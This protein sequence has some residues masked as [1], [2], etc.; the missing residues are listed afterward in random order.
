MIRKILFIIIS[1]VL[2][3]PIIFARNVDV[4][5]T[6]VE[7]LE[8]SNKVTAYD[9][10][11]HEDT[12]NLDLKFKFVDD[13][14][15]YKI[16]IISKESEDFNLAVSSNNKYLNVEVNPTLVKANTVN[17]IYITVKYNEQIPS[18]LIDND[19][20][21]QVG[22][23]FLDDDNNVVNPNTMNDFIPIFLPFFVSI[24]FFAFLII[25]K[26]KK[27]ITRY[28]LF[29]LL[30]LS[31]IPICVGALRKYHMI[32]HIDYIVQHLV[33]E[34]DKG[35]AVNGKINE[36]SENHSILRFSRSYVLPDYVEK[37]VK[38]EMLELNDYE[39]DED[40]IEVSKSFFEHNNTY[41]IIDCY[42][43]SSGEKIYVIESDMFVPIEKDV[44]SAPLIGNV[45]II[46]GFNENMSESAFVNKMKVAY[47]NDGFGAAIFKYKNTDKVEYYLYNPKTESVYLVNENDFYEN[48][49]TNLSY[50]EKLQLFSSYIDILSSINSDL[51]I[52]GWFDDGTL[53]YY[54]DYKYPLLNSDSS[55]MFYNLS[56][57]KYVDGIETIESTNT[58]T[59]NSMF[60]GCNSLLELNL[61]N[62]DM[63]NVKDVYS[64]VYGLNEL[65]KL[66]TPKKYFTKDDM[67]ISLLRTFELENNADE[68]YTF[69]DVYSPL[70]TTLIIQDMAKF[71]DGYSFAMRIK[72]LAGTYTTAYTGSNSS[73]ERIAR[74]NVLPSNFIASFKNTLSATNSSFPIY[75]WYSSS[76]KTLYYYTK[77][78]KIYLNE[79]SNYMFYGLAGLKIIDDFDNVDTS[80]VVNMREMFRSDYN[81]SDFSFLKKWDTSNV[82]NMYGLFAG[83]SKLVDL[84]N[85]S[86]WDTSNVTDMGSLFQYDYYIKSLHGLENW[87]T[88]KVTNMSYMFDKG[89]QYSSTIS[90]SVES[91]TPL[92]NWDTGNVTN[93][94]N[95]F[96]GCTNIESL[97]GL[98][99]WD[100]SKVTD[101]HEMFSGG[102]RGVANR[103]DT[104]ISD[105]SA[106][107]NWDTSNV[108][109]MGAMFSGGK[110]KD[111][112]A[113]K[114]WNVSKVK[115]INQMFGYCKYLQ[116]ITGL[117][118]WDTSSLVTLSGA[119]EYAGSL[120]SGAF[121]GDLSGWDVSN[122]SNFSYMFW[123]TGNSASNFNIGDL[124][125]W[126]LSNATNFY[127][128]FNNSGIASTTWNIG[129]L[130]SW[131]VSNVTNMD[132]MFY[133]AG[134]TSNNWGIGDL[135]NWDTRKVTSMK[136]MFC[137]ISHNKLIKPLG[138]I[139]IYGANIDGMFQNTQ[140]AIATLNVHHRPASYSGLF[141]DA[142]N[143][144]GAK[145]IVNHTEDVSF[146]D[147]KHTT[148]ILNGTWGNIVEGEILDQ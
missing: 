88:S 87:N 128:M 17:E 39:T 65:E 131:D 142:A 37:N 58:K 56:N 104:N 49:V 43:D 71:T 54:V 148:E 143:K 35:I 8:H 140:G 107:S 41:N 9:G 46:G 105:I 36:L 74:S 23:I 132:Y 110:M 63:S 116:D 90:M 113:L 144:N 40:D 42:E 103:L 60:Y 81:L 12:I 67:S 125:Q 22:L 147:L 53:Y 21:A 70:Q 38:N 108:T 121:I 136:Y 31:F 78:K 11:I 99:N 123:S 139:H 76:D 127:Y 106:L 100:V 62:F 1:L 51:P 95:M 91:L 77:A 92:L 14:A 68:I 130:S 26:N 69:L 84:T 119:F 82:E 145:I 64:M 135:S 109:D 89:A 28:V 122:V 118:N 146:R 30:L 98:E 3:L 134:F 18:D 44:K 15:K 27:N 120:V 33:V 137:A 57:M 101:M 114:N 5:I 2:F 20:K 47:E 6:D 115:N 13:Y 141:F 126:D 73:I 72:N 97:H 111:L 138:T 96:F 55:K 129:D 102:I 32:I 94:K 52:F 50:Q 93:M 16:T 25:F 112:N 7:L 59:M 4:T 83:C 34:F 133:H 48:L 66:I 75:V 24:L 45:E 79:Y 80:K 117:K 10:E 61:S 86:L 29:F 19:L 124:G 85:L